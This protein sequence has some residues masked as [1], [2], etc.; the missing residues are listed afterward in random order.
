METHI[1]GRE[2]TLTGAIR[3]HVHRRLGFALGRFS[4]RIQVV[5]VML[6]DENGPKGG[7]DKTCR[8]RVNLRGQNEI[9]VEQV[10]SDVYAAI[11]RAADRVGRTVARQLDR[12]TAF[13]PSSA[14]P[15]RACGPRRNRERK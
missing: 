11:D 1:A 7:L 2:F 12:S 10:D 14:E 8:I 9:V 3:V 15:A 4:D 13:A 5:R 6:G